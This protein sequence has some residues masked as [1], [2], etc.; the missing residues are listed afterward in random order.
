M[1]IKSPNACQCRFGQANILVG[2]SYTM[3]GSNSKI[4][5]TEYIKMYFTVI[6]SNRKP[7]GSPGLLASKGIYTASIF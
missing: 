2:T 4:I 1:L 7:S 6:W 3:C 5:K